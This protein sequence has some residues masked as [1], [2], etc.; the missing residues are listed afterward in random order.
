MVEALYHYDKDDLI[1]EVLKNV[2]HIHRYLQY[3]FTSIAGLELILKQ[4]K[5]KLQ[6]DHAL[7]GRLKLFP[8]EEEVFYTLHFACYAMEQLTSHYCDTYE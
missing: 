2:N 8:I 3:P 7:P 1:F 4:F 5:P 6:L